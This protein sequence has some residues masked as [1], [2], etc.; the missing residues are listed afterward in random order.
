MVTGEIL[1]LLTGAE[2]ETEMEEIEAGYEQ[3]KQMSVIWRKQTVKGSCFR[4]ALSCCSF[5]SV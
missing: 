2:E 4:M 1:V 3:L 5:F